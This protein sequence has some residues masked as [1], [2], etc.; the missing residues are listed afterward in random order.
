MTP[1]RLKKSDGVSN[2]R[3]DHG[4][5]RGNAS[6]QRFGK[7]A[8]QVPAESA[9]QRAQTICNSKTSGANEFAR[10]KTNDVNWKSV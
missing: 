2:P 9:G 10:F 7:H 3:L 4:D 5:D 8:T 1:T 6:G